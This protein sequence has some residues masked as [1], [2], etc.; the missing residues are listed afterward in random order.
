MA[1]CEEGVLAQAEKLASYMGGDMDGTLPMDM[2]QVQERSPP[3]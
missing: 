1:Y 2:E 3:E